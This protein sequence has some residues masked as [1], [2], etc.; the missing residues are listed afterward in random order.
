[1]FRCPTVTEK[2]S[3]LSAGRRSARSFTL[4]F[5][6]FGF[7]AARLDF[8]PDGRHRQIVR[9]IEA[10]AAFLNRYGVP[11]SD[12]FWILFGH[13]IELGRSLKAA[14]RGSASVRYRTVD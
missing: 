1:M 7:L 10:I 5:Q 12:V 6:P 4:S 3:R 11:A 8:R 9:G 14:S 2:K 13:A